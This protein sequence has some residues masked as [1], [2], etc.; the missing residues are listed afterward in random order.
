MNDAEQSWDYSSDHHHH[1][2]HAPEALV[3]LQDIHDRPCGWSQDFVHDEQGGVS[4]SFVV[5]SDAGVLDAKV[6]ARPGENRELRPDLVL[7]PD[8]IPPRSSYIPQHG[9]HSSPDQLGP[10]GHVTFN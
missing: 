7:D 10:G 6:L 2:H 4:T 3:F 9:D 1:H 5:S 8:L